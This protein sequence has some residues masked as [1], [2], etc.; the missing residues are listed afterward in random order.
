MRIYGLMLGLGLGI[1]TA[2]SAD[3]IQGVIADWDCVKP[4]VKNGREQTLRQNRSCSLMKNYTR[5]AYGLITDDKKF[6]KLDDPQNQHVLELLRNTPDKD[7]LKVIVRG[8]LNGD[9]LK[10]DSMSIL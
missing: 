2:V 5:T 7:N 10:V 6:Y 9:T 8:T 4:M 3:E 1:S